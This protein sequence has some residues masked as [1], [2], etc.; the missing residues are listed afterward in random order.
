M[1]EDHQPALFKLTIKDLTSLGFHHRDSTSSPALEAFLASTLNL[2]PNRVSIVT[3]IED[4]EAQ[5]I[6]FPDAES[7]SPKDVDVDAVARQLNSLQDAC[8][9][10]VIDVDDSEE[11]SIDEETALKLW[12]EQA[13]RTS[14]LPPFPSPDGEMIAPSHDPSLDS[15]TMATGD[16]FA[17]PTESQLR[18]DPTLL[19]FDNVERIHV[20]DPRIR[21]KETWELPFV[22]SGISA[23]STSDLLLE[24]TLIENFKEIEVRTGNRETLADNG[25]VN[26]LPLSLI[27]ALSPSSG[28]TDHPECGRIVFSPVQE[29]SPDFRAHLR[30]FACAFPGGG[31]KKFTLTLAREGF[32]IGFHKHNAAM[33]MLVVGRKKWYLGPESVEDDKPT[34]P[35][36]YTTKSSHKCIQQPGEV[37]HVPSNWYHEIFNLD[38]YTAGLQALPDE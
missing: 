15:S 12:R 13:D 10:T 16:A 17:S 22:I 23:A 20:D 24:Q 34:H 19:E 38:P 33:F 1:D 9:C 26:S 31:D 27:D 35:D 2:S 32:G 3:D 29:L 8:T 25:F 37:L 28:F 30:P 5:F 21:K 7:E 36:F 18:R 4:G 14:H 11:E 6:V